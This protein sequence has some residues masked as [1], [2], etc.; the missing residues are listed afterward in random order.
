M[1][2][3][4]LLAVLGSV[5][6]LAAAAGPASEPVS[7]AAARK[8]TG[9]ALRDARVHRDRRY[10]GVTTERRCLDAPPICVPAGANVVIRSSPGAAP[11]LEAIVP[12]AALEAFGITWKVGEPLALDV[13]SVTGT[14]AAPTRVGDVRLRETVTLR[15]G[16]GRVD[17][18]RGVLHRPAELMGFVVPAGCR[19]RR[20]ADGFVGEMRCT[21]S[22]A[23]ARRV[24][25]GSVPGAPDA[26]SEWT[27]ERTPPR[28]KWRGVAAEPFTGHGATFRPG[29]V[30]W[31]FLDSSPPEV[32]PGA[33][34]TVATTAA[35]FELDGVSF[36]AGAT[37]TLRCGRV[38]QAHTG[39]ALT[40]RVRGHQ[41]TALLATRSGAPY[42]PEQACGAL[43]GF[44]IALPGARWE[45]GH[46]ARAWINDTG[47]LW[48]IH[49]SQLELPP[50]GPD[51]P[52]SPA[53]STNPP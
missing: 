20:E 36:P 27:V 31:E 3:A 23:F 7:E 29:G 47:E 34:A 38:E 44:Q 19:F 5:L 24:V 11:R 50:G 28:T 22:D 37:V 43:H 6:L 26:L 46:D 41:T 16:T 12:T 40:M 49:R 1:H 15:L 30:A 8:E 21:V 32:P 51:V 33:F 17:V 35:P 13:G 4:A 9:F 52:D 45:D 53:H 39:G 42:T 2:P 48:R 10:T 18:E 25:P 14:L